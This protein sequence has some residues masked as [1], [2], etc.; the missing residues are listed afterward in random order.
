MYH[1]NGRKFNLVRISLV[2]AGCP[3]ELSS[4]NANRSLRAA[5]VVAKNDQKL[6][7]VQATSYCPASIV[8][9]GA[10]TRQRLLEQGIVRSWAFVEAGAMEIHADDAIGANELMEKLRRLLS[11][12]LLGPAQS[13]NIMGRETPWIVEVYPF[14]NYFVYSYSGERYRQ[15]YSL[16][17]TRREVSLV[18]NEQ[19]VFEKFVTAGDAKESMPDSETGAR[20]SYGYTKGNVQSFTTGGRNSELVTSTIRNLSNVQGAVDAYLNYLRA[21]GKKIPM[22]PSFAPV[23]LSNE[24]KILQALTAAGVDILDFLLW[25]AKNSKN[26]GYKAEKIDRGSFAMSCCK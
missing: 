26:R 20:K 22:R 13:I 1:L 17:A 19:K 23:A 24:G 16:D 14:E 25:S 6:G 2:R 3:L 10:I 9:A 7:F 11:D 4:T 15:A 5:I 21:Q 12:K 18:G 8:V